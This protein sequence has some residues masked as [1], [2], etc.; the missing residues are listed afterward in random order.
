MIYTFGDNIPTLSDD[1]P[2]PSQWIKQKPHPVRMRF[3]LVDDQGICLWQSV[4]GKDRGEGRDEI[5]VLPPRANPGN[6][7][8]FSP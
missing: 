2:L 7:A 8:G 6:N 4:V 5:S 3:C 1:I